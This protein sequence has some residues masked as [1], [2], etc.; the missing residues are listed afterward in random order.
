MSG[1]MIGKDLSLAKWPVPARIAVGL[2]L[3]GLCL[4]LPAFIALFR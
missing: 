3:L 1:N 2:G 4:W